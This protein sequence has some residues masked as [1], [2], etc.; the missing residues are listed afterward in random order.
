[1]ITIERFKN[2]KN[3]IFS[4]A[5]DQQLMEEIE[6]KLE[7]ITK[8]P[9]YAGRLHKAL[10]NGLMDIGNVH[11]FWLE[12]PELRH[13][14]LV[15]GNHVGSERRARKLGIQG[16]RRIKDA[17][18]FIRTHKQGN[19][20][21]N[22][23]QE[24]IKKVAQLIEPE[25][26]A[27]GYRT[28]EVTLNIPGYRPPKPCQIPALMEVFLREIKEGDLHPVERA[29]GVHLTLTGI[30]P[31]LDGNKRTARLLQDG[32]LFDYL[33]PPAIIPTGERDIYVTL[34][35]RALLNPANI[36]DQRPFCD[37]IGG[38]VNAVFRPQGSRQHL[39][40]FFFPIIY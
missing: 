10:H 19:L 15:N 28:E 4:M 13:N 16:I 12:Y 25:K 40:H 39:L 2:T 37:Y 22:L 6:L 34:L 20:L 21:S 29:A 3:L 8:N 1:M 31:F 33:I 23:D 24:S 9:E 18:Y 11:S 38:K 14:L 30:Q 27:N 17:W 32:L 5:I 36:L 35:S 26:N 7:V